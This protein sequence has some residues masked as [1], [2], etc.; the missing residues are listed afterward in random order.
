M[1]AELRR[2]AEEV[3]GF[4]PVEEGLALH[5]AAHDAPAGTLLEV[6]SYCGK[7]SIYLGSAA[8]ERGSVLISVDHH[9]GSEENQ[10]GWAYH[11]QS[12]VDQVSGRIDTL[13]HLRATL[14]RAGLE[15]HV[16][17]VVARSSALAQLWERPLALVFIDGGHTE[18]AASAD[19]DGWAGRV[20]PGGLLAIHDVFPDPTDGGQAPFH[21]Y[22][23]SLADGFVEAS[24]TGSLRV[25]RR[26][27]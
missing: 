16:I 26:P 15:E 1:S 22:Q 4:M 21:V 18:E 14:A 6:G 20:M 19:Y 23:R 12:L 10:P 24:A 5:Q 11:D 9:R 13:P 7:S 17:A 2:L 8:R 3:R 25:L 27:G